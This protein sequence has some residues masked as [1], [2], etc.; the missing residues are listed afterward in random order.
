MPITALVAAS[1]SLKHEHLVP[2]R[3]AINTTIREKTFEWL[4]SQEYSF[5]PSQANFFMLDTKRPVKEV[6]AAMAA[7]KVFIGR[8]WPVWPTHARITVGTQAEMDAF[9]AAF[10][11]V[12]KNAKTVSYTLPASGPGSHRDYFYADGT[13]FPLA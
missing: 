3:K 5:T 4:R 1:G 2:E 6:I 12:M 8:P 11:K 13:R 9:Q 7:E 10:A